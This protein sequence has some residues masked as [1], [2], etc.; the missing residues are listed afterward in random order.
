MLGKGSLIIVM[1]FVVAISTYQLKL[2]KSVL[3]ASDNFNYYYMRTMVHENALS[4]MNFGINKVWIDDTTS[5]N[6]TV[7]TDLCTSSVSIAPV[8]MDTVRLRVNAWGYVYDD[9]NY[10]KYGKPLKVSDSVF[11]YFAY[12]TPMSRYFWF[13]DQEAGVYWI[14]GDTVEGPL[15][16]NGVLRTNGSPVF[17]GKVSAGGGIAPAP[18]TG[19]SRANFYGGWEVGQ[20]IEIPTDMSPLINAAVTGNGA[21]PTNTKCIYDTETTFEFLSNGDVVRTVG[22]NP[23][24][25]VTL[26]NI[27]PTGVIYSTANVRV[28]GTFNGQLT[29]Y[30]ENNLRIDDDIVYADD[31]NVNPNSDDILG[32][33]SANDVI[34][35]DNPANNNDVSIQS[36]IMAVNGSF[37][38]ENYS[39]RPVSGVIRLTGSVVQNSRGPVGTFNK[40]SGSIT[41]GFNKRYKYD[42]RLAYMSSPYYPFIRVL[43]LVLWWE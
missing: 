43:R 23:A 37:T 18:W 39:G 33:V 8:G 40:W 27:A 5:G 30:T 41:H 42:E 1:A 20:T 24:D 14:T 35:S 38:A 32:L 21:A 36:A 22:A 4:A 25:T 15:H 17:Y 26:T 9:E 13:T 19:G 3:S 11:A 12:N 7:E 10:D 29:I 31:P 28:K 34:I 16:T 2:N 6:F